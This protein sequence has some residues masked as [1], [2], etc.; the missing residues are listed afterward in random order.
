M[1]T[2]LK[3]VLQLSS[4]SSTSTQSNKSVTHKSTR[5]PPS[6]LFPLW[7]VVT[8][9]SALADDSSMHR[10]LSDLVHCLVV[11][12]DETTLLSYLNHLHSL[13]SVFWMSFFSK[14]IGILF[15]QLN[16]RFALVASGTVGIVNYFYVKNHLIS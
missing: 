3:N 14:F 2:Y 10:H 7:K 16:K 11:S 8:S 13:V 5:C 9:L 6:L 15:E 12:T 4:H 1:L